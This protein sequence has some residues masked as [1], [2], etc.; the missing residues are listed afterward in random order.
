MITPLLKFQSLYASQ[1]LVNWEEVD[2]IPVDH[3]PPCFIISK[4]S[5]L[6]LRAPSSTNCS[7]KWYGGCD[8]WYD[9]FRNCICEPRSCP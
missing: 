2:L 1:Y 4:Y 5:I 3:Y 9:W 7:A 6:L 8:W